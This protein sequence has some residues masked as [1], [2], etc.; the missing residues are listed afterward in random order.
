MATWVVSPQK[1]LASDEVRGLRRIISDA[2]TLAKARGVQC[3]VRDQLIIE[4]A[5]GTG[6]RVSEISNLKVDDL[7]LKK[8]QNTLHVRNGKGG[9]ARTVQFS[10]GLKN[11]IR[12][13][14][15][16]RR[17]DSDYLFPSQRNPR[18]TPSGLQQTFKRWAA[19]AGLPKR[20]SI[21]C[22]RH[23]YATRLHKASGYNLRL[24]QKQLG[25]SSV[26]TTQVYADVLDEDVTKALACLDLE[27]E[28]PGFAASTNA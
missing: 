26:S 6:L 1:F 14:L 15:D 24:V 12:G 9:K 27:Q 19:K 11:L 23:T 13:Y 4:L 21:H 2:A 25:H 22:L 8:G 5:L 16:Y 3:A 7:Y 20:Y 17:T 18:M 10:P 28:Q